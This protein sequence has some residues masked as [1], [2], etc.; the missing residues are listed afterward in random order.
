M[1]KCLRE[2]NTAGRR[3]RGIKKR[4]QG[5]G[6]G[7]RLWSVMLEE[8]IDAEMLNVVELIMIKKND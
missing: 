7:T 8:E 2:C 1:M 4:R 3:Q 6:E 5:V